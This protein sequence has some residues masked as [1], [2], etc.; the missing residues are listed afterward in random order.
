MTVEPGFGGQKFMADMLSKVRVVR[1]QFPAVHIQVDGGLTTG[2]SPEAA[3]AGA[4]VIVAGTAIF[5]APNAA[6]AISQIR[7]AVDGCKA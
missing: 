6:E 1:E 2:N 7:A 3:A 4:N 5:G